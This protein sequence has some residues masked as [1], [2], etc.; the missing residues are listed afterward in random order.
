[1]KWDVFCH[2][3]DNHGDIGVCWRLAADLGARGHVVRLWVDDASA[4]RWMAPHGAVGVDVHP[5]ADSERAVPAEVVVESF[6]C[7]LP[8]AYVHNMAAAPR[9]PRWINLEYL[10]AEAYVERSHCLPSPQ[11]SGPG[12]G[13]V[14]HFFYPGFT[15][16]TGG[17]IRER[18]LLDR[19]AQFDRVAWLQEHRIELL[20]GERLVSLFSYAN[21][22]LGELLRSLATAPT[23]VLFAAGMPV[24]ASLPHGVRGITMPYL[25]Q[26]DYDRLLW[27]CDLNFVRGE[28]SFVR[29]QWAGRPFVWHIYPQDDGAHA[30]KL[31]AFLDRFPPVEGLPEFWSAWNGLGAWPARLPP[32]W[33]AACEAWRGQLLTQVDLTTQLVGFAG[34][35]G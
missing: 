8:A 3:V 24:P 19:I 29:A 18:G 35:A 12:R 27:S 34:E 15:S 28:D 7:D 17:L 31:Q 14:K 23:L 22:C 32:P 11:L 33:T 4:L 26:G 13:L 25:S 2:V 6:G 16:A 9:P 10:S 21:P 5:W 20:P 1:M 30:T